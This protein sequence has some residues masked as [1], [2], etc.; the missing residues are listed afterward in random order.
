EKALETLD[1]AAQQLGDRME[2]R[3]ACA[4]HWALPGQEGAAAA[5]AKLEQDSGKFTLEEESQLFRG[6]ASAQMR[7][8][9][10]AEAKRLYTQVAAKQPKDLPSRLLLFDLAMQAGDDK[11]LV[12]LIEEIRALEGEDGALWRFAKA[13]RSLADARKGE[14]QG[15]AEARTLLSEAAARRPSWAALRSRDA[16]V[17]ELE[18]NQSGAI[19]KYRQAIELGERNS[20]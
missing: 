14:K 5:L 1:R 7:L 4:R 20:L 13:S 9:N 2:I 15:L 6:L 12:R 19:D 18:G 3:L 8:G 17:C 16:E 10:T 11:A